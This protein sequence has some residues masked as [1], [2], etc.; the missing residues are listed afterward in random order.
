M[1]KYA[2]AKCV[3][4]VKC[5]LQQYTATLRQLFPACLYSAIFP[6]N[7]CSAVILKNDHM[8]ASNKKCHLF[9][10]TQTLQISET[11]DIAPGYNKEI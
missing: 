4:K 10:S 8:V 7:G 5:A 3:N 9:Q 2:L 11:Y 6:N 1:C